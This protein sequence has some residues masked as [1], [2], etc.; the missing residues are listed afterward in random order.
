MD[1]SPNLERSET[2]ILN[3]NDDCMREVIQY[4]DANDLAVV[5]D[6]CIRFRQNAVK[7]AH[8]KPKVLYLNDYTSVVDYSRFRNF[9]TTIKSV[10]VNCYG[11]A[12]HQKRLIQ[13]LSRY[14]IGESIELVLR[15]Y[16]INEE[17][18]F[19][20]RPLLERVTKLE[21][22]TCRF[23]MMLQR[24]LPLWSPELRELKYTYDASNFSFDQGQLFPKLESISFE[25]TNM[26]KSHIELFLE[27]NP[28]L[29]EIR[30]IFCKQLD[31]DI[32]Q[33]IAKYVPE[34]E[35]ITFDA[36]Y[37]THRMNIKF[38]GLL[39]ELKSLSMRMD[40]IAD[41][42]YVQLVVHEIAAANIPLESLQLVGLD[43]RNETQ[44][45]VEGISKLTKLKI[46]RLQRVKNMTASQLIEMC[47]SLEELSEIKLSAEY[48]ILTKN[49]LLE[50][51]LNGE[52]LHK[53]DCSTTLIVLLYAYPYIY[54]DEIL[55][56]AEILEQR[57]EKT[58]FNLILEGIDLTPFYSSI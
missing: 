44:R 31:D 56:L 45:F 35:R 6:V 47:K 41:K 7:I 12:N 50:L 55:E 53:F 36:N 21:F 54:N 17:M 46:L 8:L 28:Q 4:L 23:S 37:P 22:D 34:I 13:S 40:A 30:V 57:S 43:L 27:K 5:A 18:A 20:T 39:R 32:F 29:K 15:S 51:V 24:N 1:A 16:E 25:R 26:E 58:K 33:W 10:D 42:S 2:T 3:V 14:C 38:C 48:F 11:R 9:G 49:E 19:I 52:E